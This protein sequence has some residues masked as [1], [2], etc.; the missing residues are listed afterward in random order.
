MEKE[1]KAGCGPD[2]KKLQEKEPDRQEGS[3]EKRMRK[4][5]EEKEEE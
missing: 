1:R 3:L 5:S 4:K 2:Q